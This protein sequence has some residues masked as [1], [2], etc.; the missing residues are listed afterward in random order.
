M[1]SNNIISPKQY[2]NCL[3]REGKLDIQ[4][5]NRLNEDNCEKLFT[6]KQSESPGIYNLTQYRDC[7]CGVPQVVE[8]A[9]ENPM[10]QFR[11]GYGISECF[12]DEDS[13]LRVGQTKKNPKVPNQLFTRPYKTVPYMGRGSGDSFVESQL[14]VGEDTFI[15]KQCN[16]LSG[17]NIPN[18]D[19]NHM[20]M[21]N[22]LK[23]NIQN[24]IH[25]IPHDALEGWV[26]GG[27]PSRQIVRDIEYLERC[28][29]NYHK[30]AMEASQRNQ[31]HFDPRNTQ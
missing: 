30:Q 28:G 20:P 31:V 22:H 14:R 10:I 1:S 25:I 21:I 27:A 12:M 15:R 9:V 5:P 24:P 6:T 26:R 3:R 4:N 18:V 8:T 19:P 23:Q 7:Q 2:T 16:T 29:S 11:D 13:D 17:I